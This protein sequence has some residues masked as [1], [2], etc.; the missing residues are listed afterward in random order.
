MKISI[1]FV[2]LIGG[3]LIL[4]SMSAYSRL[5][6][7]PARAPVVT[8]WEYA[9]LS[10]AASDSE[11]V[12]DTPGKEVREEELPNDTVFPTVKFFHDLSGIWKMPPSPPTDCDFLNQIGKLGWELT[13]ISNPPK[14]N[15]GLTIYVFKRP[16]SN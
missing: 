16:I 4:V 5:S 11:I 10:T 14:D 8:R 13:G 1:K 12:F 3:I 7:D 9:E 6:A 15:D 2:G